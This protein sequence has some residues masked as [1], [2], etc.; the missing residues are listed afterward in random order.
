MCLEHAG[1]AARLGQPNDAFVSPDPY[2]G[3]SDLQWVD[4]DIRDFQLS[5]LSG[6]DSEFLE[7]IG[8]K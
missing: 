4:G 3:P 6:L 5:N 2:Q 1:I 8:L 7:G